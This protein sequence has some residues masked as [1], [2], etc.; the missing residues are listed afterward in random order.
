MRLFLAYEERVAYATDLFVIILCFVK[1][2]MVLPTIFRQGGQ[3]TSFY[4]LWKLRGTLLVLYI[5]YDT[6]AKRWRPTK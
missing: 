6:N 4:I 2:Q 3:Q 5:I 1:K